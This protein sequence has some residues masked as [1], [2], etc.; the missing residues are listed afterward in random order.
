MEE[1]G[2]VVTN[3]KTRPEEWTNAL[4]NDKLSMKEKY[5]RVTAAAKHIEQQAGRMELIERHKNS[6]NIQ[7]TEDINDRYVEAIRAKLALLE[8]LWS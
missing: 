2:V 6:G 8:N 7:N 3:E 5:E 1:N 4:H